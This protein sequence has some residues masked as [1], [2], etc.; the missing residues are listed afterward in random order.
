MKVFCDECDLP[1]IHLHHADNVPVVEL[2]RF[3]LRANEISVSLRGNVQCHV[4]LGLKIFF[5]DRILRWEN[6][7]P[8]ENEKTKSFRTFVITIRRHK[9]SAQFTVCLGGPISMLHKHALNFSF[10]RL[11]IAT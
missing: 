3:S 2:F 11:L 7:L 9:I 10:I 8:Q 6:V 1:C 4:T 5:Q